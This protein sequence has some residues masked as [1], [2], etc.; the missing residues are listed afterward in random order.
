MNEIREIPERKMNDLIRHSSEA[1]TVVHRGAEELNDKALRL[2]S[3]SL[4]RLTEKL[5]ELDELC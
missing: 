3:R 4:K 5:M 1:Q 2:A